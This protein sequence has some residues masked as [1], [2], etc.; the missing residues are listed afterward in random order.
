MSINVPCAWVNAAKNDVSEKRDFF[1][2]RKDSLLVSINT[3]GNRRK[4]ITRD[5]LIPALIIHPKVI[6]GRILQNSSEPKPAI[7]VSAA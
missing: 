5:T 3:D 6:T 2:G 1:P 4:V 7:V